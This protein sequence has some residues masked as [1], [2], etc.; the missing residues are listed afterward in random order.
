MRLS[1]VRLSNATWD[2]NHTLMAG[3]TY[4]NLLAEAIRYG[5]RREYGKACEILTRIASEADD[6]PLA[7]M[8]LGRSHHAMNNHAKAIGAFT[9]YL[10]KKPDDAEGWFFLGRSFL[11]AQRAR[12]ALRCINKARSLGKTNAQCLALAGFAEL[13]LHRAVHAVKTLEQAHIQDPEDP[14]IFRAYR[15]ALFVLSIGHL[16]KGKADTARQ[17]L[18]FVIAN[19]GDTTTARL[20]R[21]AASREAGKLELA[22]ADLEKAA[23]DNPGD[24][25]IRLQL[26]VLRITTGHYD[27]GYKLLDELGMQ[28]PGTSGTPWSATMLE[29]WRALTA[30][31]SGQTRN[32]LQSALALLRAG[33][34]EPMVRVITAQAN[35]E[36]GRYPQAIEHFKRAAEADPASPAIRLALALA[37]WETGNY[38]AA[39]ST[40]SAAA[41]RGAD[42]LDSSYLEVLCQARENFPPAQ[43][44]PKVQELL[45]A[46]PGDQRLIFILAECLYKTGRPELAGPWFEKVIELDHINDLARLYL[47]SIAESLQNE[48]LILKRYNEYLIIFPDNNAIRREYIQ[49]LIDSLQWAKALTVLEDGFP[50]DS[51]SRSNSALLATCYRHTE[52]YREAAIHYRSL[53]SAEPKNQDYLL[54]LALCLE[55][56]G[57]KE[58]AVELLQRGAK[59]LG[60]Q[61]EP[62]LALGV[63]LARQNQSEAACSAFAKVVELAPAD[64]RPLR[65]L[66]IL[67]RKSGSAEMA[68]RYEAKAARLS[69]ASH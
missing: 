47:I 60:R 33:D 27:S 23:S 48:E 62:W 19:G 68:A 55:K 43:L 56:S 40:A 25:G 66:A 4:Q 9:A 6:V 21:A 50:Y 11:A 54:A 26:A 38:P 1:K 69:G 17:M 63:L 3:K 65:Q 29:R 18:D 2:D 35:L 36:L 32:A 51:A 7:L 64:P 41:H 31:Q 16:N 67:Y 28:L 14:A 15:N 57:A 44:L 22:L 5:N 20:Y 52:R 37:Y 8:Y 59:Y 42:R 34:K 61:A 13:K 12:E 46:K 49:K 58:L 45:R 30:L 39:R 10:A 24:K 53:L